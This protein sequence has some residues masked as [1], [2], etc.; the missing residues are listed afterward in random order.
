MSNLFIFDRIR[1][2]VQFVAVGKA[3]RLY[4]IKSPAHR[5]MVKVIDDRGQEKQVSIETLKTGVSKW[6]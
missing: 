3:N 1:P 2:G 6:L 4:T 5:G